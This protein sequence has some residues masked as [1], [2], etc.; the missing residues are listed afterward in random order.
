M[1]FRIHFE[2]KGSFWCIQFQRFYMYWESA[3][4]SDNVGTPIAVMKFNNYDE[5]LTYVKEQGIDRVYSQVNR[6]E[7]PSQLVELSD[8]IEMLK[9]NRS[10]AK[11]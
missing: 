2:P 7:S 3:M 5:A 1:F 9:N 4:T 11:A 8:I 6:I 10:F